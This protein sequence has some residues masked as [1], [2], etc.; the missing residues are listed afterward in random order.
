MPDTGAQCDLTN[1]NSSFGNFGLVAVGLGSTQ[2]TGKVNADI[3]PGDNSDVVV[4]KGVTD[5]SD[6]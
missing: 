6:I 4:G 2:F 1:S 5:S 3:V